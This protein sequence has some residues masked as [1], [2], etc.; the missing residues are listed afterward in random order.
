M[1]AC[2]KLLPG[3]PVKTLYEKD[4]CMVGFMDNIAFLRHL[5]DTHADSV[6][7]VFI[8]PPFAKQ[9]D[10][11]FAD[12][13]M[14]YSDRLS[15]DMFLSELALRLTLAE[16]LVAEDGLFWLY[17]D[18]TIGHYVKTMMDKTFRKLRF[19]N[20]VIVPRVRKNGDINTL[21]NAHDVIYLYGTEKSRLNPVYREDGRRTKTP[22]WH[23]FTA[24]GQGAAKIFDGVILTPPT[25][26]HWRWSQEHIDQAMANGT[27]RI[28]NGRPE[29]LVTPKKER[30]DTLWTDIPAYSFS[31]KYPTEK[32]EKLLARIIE[33]STK[34]GDT[35]LDFYAGSGTT[36][37]VALKM[38]RK[39]LLC[40]QSPASREVILRRLH[41]FF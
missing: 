17:I 11:R 38:G 34:T 7:C 22:Y 26:T 18:Y 36:G 27:L 35:V 4:G 5:V 21:N 31:T 8:D 6:N 28:R 10:F 12:G 32:S 13:T 37:A 20:E 23:D 33:S 16:K 9:Q 14:A 2:P 1:S 24:K 29:Y 25:G 3:S 19:L 15:P 30:V 39:F 40:D 41:G